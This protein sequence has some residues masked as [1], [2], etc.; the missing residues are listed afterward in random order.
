MAVPAQTTGYSPAPNA[1]PPCLQ[2]PRSLA[3]SCRAR[4]P[5][6]KGQ[7][8]RA[9]KSP[10]SGSREGVTPTM[11]HRPLAAETGARQPLPPRPPVLTAMRGQSLEGLHQADGAAALNTSPAGTHT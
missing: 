7:S 11:T 1:G 4:R 3:M 6:P 2:K 5:R 9:L 8:S 10:R